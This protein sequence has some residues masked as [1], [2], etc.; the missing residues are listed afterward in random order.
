M[1]RAGLKKILLE[2]EIGLINSLVENF[3][4]GRLLEYSN[5]LV[6]P[7]LP[8]RSAVIVVRNPLPFMTFS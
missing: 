2:A 1:G 5:F 4:R 8:S 7:K 3:A 6:Y